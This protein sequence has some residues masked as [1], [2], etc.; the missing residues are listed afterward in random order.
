MLTGFDSTID[1]VAGLKAGADD[2]VSK[3]AREEE[4]IAP[5]GGSPH[6][7]ARAIAA[8]SGMSASAC[9]P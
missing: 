7:N 9:S 5:G 8:R 6:R 4:L 2:Y 1:A 3:T